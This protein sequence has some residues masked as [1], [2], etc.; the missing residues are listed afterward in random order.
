[1]AN[2]YEAELHAVFTVCGVPD[3]AIR[4]YALIILKKRPPRDGKIDI[5]EMA[6]KMA[7][8]TQPRPKGCYLELLL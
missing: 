8:R 2:L 7:S 5:A 1:M 4:A 6:S 3:P